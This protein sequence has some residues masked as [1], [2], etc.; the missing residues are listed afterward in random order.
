MEQARRLKVQ[1]QDVHEENMTTLT[2]LSAKPLESSINLVLVRVDGL[3]HTVIC[4]CHWIQKTG[5]L[6]CHGLAAIHC[7]MPVWTER[8]STDD[9]IWY[10]VPY[11]VTTLQKMYVPIPML[12]TSSDQW[13]AKTDLSEQCH[14]KLKQEKRSC[15]YQI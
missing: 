8:M 6:Y 2:V 5:W 12:P 7:T 11:H 3:S 14:R 4:H 15:T 1:V 9:P 13:E 10:S